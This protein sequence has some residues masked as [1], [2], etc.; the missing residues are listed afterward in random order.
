M[1]TRKYW[2]R[3]GARQGQCTLLCRA[4]RKIWGQAQVA[5]RGVRVFPGRGDVMA[6]GRRCR[7]LGTSIE[8]LGAAS[9]RALR[10]RHTP[11]ARVQ[12]PGEGGEAA[13]LAARRISVAPVH[14]IDIHGR[15]EKKIVL[16]GVCDQV[17]FRSRWIY[18]DLAQTTLHRLAPAALVVGGG[19]LGGACGLRPAACWTC[20]LCSS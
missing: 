13:S 19:C 3:G 15:L 2:E 7:R 14:R 9:C 10:Q 8:A 4:R 18:S 17:R 20:T 12:R 1:P 11:V 5:A 6:G 16:S